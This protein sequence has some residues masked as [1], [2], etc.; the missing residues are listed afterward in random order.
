MDLYDYKDNELFTLSKKTVKLIIMARYGMLDC[1]KNFKGKYG[2]ELC[3]ECNEV[4]DESHRINVCGRWEHVN[5]CKGGYSIDFNAVYS[6]EIDTIRQISRLL[7]SVWNIENGK[8]EIQVK[9]TV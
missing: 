3:K 8:N 2:S 1:A 7:R 6:E 5:L 4:D 9:D